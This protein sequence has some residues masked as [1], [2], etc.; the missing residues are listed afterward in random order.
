MIVAF[1]ASAFPTYS[2]P[3]YS[4]PI[5]GTAVPFYFPGDFEEIFYSNRQFPVIVD[6]IEMF[7][8]RRK[9]GI[10]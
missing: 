6:G 10:R 1:P 3:L 7:E 4:W 2:W 5:S 8:P 9:F